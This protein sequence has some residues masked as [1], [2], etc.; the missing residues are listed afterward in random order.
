MS[1]ENDATLSLY[2]LERGVRFV[3]LIDVGASHNWD[4]HGDMQDHLKLARA[5]DQPIAGLL[6]DLRARGLLDD[7]LVVWA[8]EFGRTP[9]LIK[10][11]PAAGRGHHRGAFSCWLAGGGA[12]VG[13]A[14]GE[15][16]ELGIEVARDPVRVR[17]FHA[18]I[19]H[20]LGLDH[21]RLTWRNGGRDERLTDVG[22]K[23]VA[24]LMA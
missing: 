8:T 15:S 9:F 11:S 22:G 3:E 6:R 19:L 1:D 24:G 10:D 20:L 18:T 14:F 16:D 2:G 23:V 4:S 21:E 5:I 13:T 17:D 12:R 7:T